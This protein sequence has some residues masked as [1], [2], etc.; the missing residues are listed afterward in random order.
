[1]KHFLLV[2]LLLGI[3]LPA[4]ATV[5]V[6]NLKETCTGTEYGWDNENS[7]YEWNQYKENWSGFLL[8]EQTGPETAQIQVVWTWKL[9]KQK[10]AEAENWGEINFIPVAFDNGKAMH[11][12]SGSDNES[13]FLFSGASKMKKISAYKAASCSM[14][15]NSI[16]SDIAQVLP[17]SLSG[18]LICDDKI[19]DPVT[20]RDLW[21]SQY[22]LSLNVKYTLEGHL[23]DAL[24][25]TDA[26]DELL[27]FLQDE[28]GYHVIW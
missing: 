3:I 1:M 9:G 16:P 25:I 18:Y 11:L 20:H 28:Q 21:T 10:Y 17:S 23:R 8:I 4:N 7:A 12:I 6:Y 24:D 27:G 26:I 22:K 13:R 2:L 14:C 15:H 19:G 5:L